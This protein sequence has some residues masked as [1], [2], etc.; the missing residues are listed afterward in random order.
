M[1]YDNMERFFD[2]SKVVITGNPVRSN[3]VQIDGKREAAIKHFDLDPNKKTLLVLGGSLGARTINQSIQAACKDLTSEGVQIIWQCGK[4]YAEDLQIFMTNEKKYA[5]L[6][7]KKHE[8]KN[9]NND[10]NKDNGGKKNPLH[11]A[12]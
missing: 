3:V 12:P 7:A 2:K 10:N 11:I 6:E 4:I 5:D 1:A 9:K 8:K